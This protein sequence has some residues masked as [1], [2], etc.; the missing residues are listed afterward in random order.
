MRLAGI[1]LRAAR[2]G[3]RAGTNGAEYTRSRGRFRA[4][5]GA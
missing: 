1:V 4:V 3:G 2:P 5:F